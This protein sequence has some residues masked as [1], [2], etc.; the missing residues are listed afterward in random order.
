MP[1]VL[2]R[3]MREAGMEAAI[4]EGVE[5]L[6]GYCWSVPDSRRTAT[7]DMPDLVIALP[8]SERE[9]RPGTVALIELKSQN[10]PV[11]A[12]QRRALDVL[13]GCTTLLTGVCRPVPRAGEIGY[14]ELLQRLGITEATS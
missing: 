5:R 7:G 13:A 4:R 9:N 11:T 1:D 3:T 14:D 2:S 6:G 8:G 12:G 10:R